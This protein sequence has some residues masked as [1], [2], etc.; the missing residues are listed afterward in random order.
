MS[1]DEVE[2]SGHPV[3]CVPRLQVRGRFQS[4]FCGNEYGYLPQYRPSGMVAVVFW[5]I[6]GSAR[7]TTGAGYWVYLIELCDKKVLP[8]SLDGVCRFR[9][10][11]KFYL[12]ALMAFTTSAKSLVGFT[13]EFL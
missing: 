1:S 9:H 13:F 11:A 7:L 10:G 6:E 2:K 8:L 5:H 12:S 4:C 3:P